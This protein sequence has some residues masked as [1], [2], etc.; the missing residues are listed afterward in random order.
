MKK[1]AFA[2]CAYLAA[3]VAGAIEI[4]EPRNVSPLF[5]PGDWVPNAKTWHDGR[6]AEIV[7]QKTMMDGKAVR[8]RIRIEYG[9][10][11]GTNSFSVTAFVPKSQKPASKRVFG[12][13]GFV[14][15][16]FPEPDTPQQG[17]DIS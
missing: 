6:R 12:K 5:P 13:K 1:I 17:G 4:A 15:S 11:Y 3:C 2:F 9:G 8:R 10:K 14:S 7:P 16:G